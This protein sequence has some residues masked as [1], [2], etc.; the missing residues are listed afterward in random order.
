M[1][2]ANLNKSKF[3]LTSTTTASKY[4]PKRP[5]ICI[6]WNSP[7]QTQIYL[8]KVSLNVNIVEQDLL[9]KK[10]RSERG[11]SINADSGPLRYLLWCCGS[12]S[13]EECTF[14]QIG[15]SH[16]VPNQLYFC[17]LV[18]LNETLLTALI[19]VFK[20]TKTEGQIPNAN[21]VFIV[22]NII[23]NLCL[24]RHSND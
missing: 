21:K 1:A 9:N 12:R 17:A 6:N 18:Y 13:Q 3:F 14:I 23:F 19:F 24:S 15:S 5:R 8:V 4:I 2:R 11:I 22:I 20:L 10:L 16:T 7:F